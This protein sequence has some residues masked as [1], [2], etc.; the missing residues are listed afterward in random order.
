MDE[1]LGKRK[2]MLMQDGASAHTSKKTTKYLRTVCKVLKH[3]PA[4]SPDLNPIEHLWSI[5]DS[6]LKANPPKTV[7]E[8]KQAV[9]E[10]WN[11]ISFDT[12]HNL[13]ASMDKRLKLVKKYGGA[14]LNG[15]WN[16]EV[17]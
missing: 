4:N 12:I 1:H 10:A 8:L 11:T 14:S 13:V 17:N 15:H 2:W 6:I 5:L 16:E 7:S 9:Q 3:W